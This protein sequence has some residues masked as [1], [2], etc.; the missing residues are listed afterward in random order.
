MLSNQIIKLDS[1][2]STNDYLKELAINGCT[3]GTA[4]IARFQNNGRGSYGK[5]FDSPSGG[6]YMSYYKHLDT[7]TDD[8][9]LITQWT[10]VSVYNAIWE[11]CKIQCQIKYINDLLYDGKK[12]C[13][14]LTE[15]SDK[16][17]I[18][19]IGINTNTKMEDLDPHI[20]ANAIS[21]KSIIGGTVDNDI[22][23]GLIISK[24]NQQFYDWPDKKWRKEFYDKNVIMN[25]KK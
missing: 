25:Q 18:I 13:G 9:C 1:I 21:L 16:N 19:G 20:R 22:L 2:G 7:L 23:S 10:A 8:L 15:I 24:L 5:S 12:L 6:L 3:D 4:V 11:Y 14:I 17:L